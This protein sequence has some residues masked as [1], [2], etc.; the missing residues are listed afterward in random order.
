MLLIHRQRR[1]A[2][3]PSR[4]WCRGALESP[5]SETRRS[6]GRRCVVPMV[7][8]AEGVL[9]PGLIDPLGSHLRPS[10]PCPSTSTSTRN[11]APH[12]RAEER[13]DEAL[14]ALPGRHGLAAC[15]PSRPTRLR[16][17]ARRRERRGCRP[18]RPHA[19]P[20]PRRLL[21]LAANVRTEQL[22]VPTL[23]RTDD[24]LYPKHDERDQRERDRHGH[25]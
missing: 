16:R 19:R 15:D 13:R 20:K 18:R 9:L 7:Q 21:A 11:E 25:E 6:R 3:T 8:A 23:A 17:A 24:V 1:V 14:A 12:R 4:R 10:S 5:G 22:D 2:E